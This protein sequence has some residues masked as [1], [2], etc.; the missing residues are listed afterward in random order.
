VE[1]LVICRL[2]MGEP[3]AT[4]R[5][6]EWRLICQRFMKRVPGV[7]SGFL[8]DSSGAWRER[9]CATVKVKR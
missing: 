8:A 6:E 4:V 5:V 9:M 1:A 3:W 2:R 7:E